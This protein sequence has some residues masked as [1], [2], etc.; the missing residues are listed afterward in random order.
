MFDSTQPAQQAQPTTN[1]ARPIKCAEPST[2]R[3][4]PTIGHSVIRK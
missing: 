2:I 1:V 4:R 3:P